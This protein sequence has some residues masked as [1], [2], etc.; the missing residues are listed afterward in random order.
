MFNFRFVLVC[1]GVELDVWF[2]FERHGHKVF[3]ATAALATL[4][5]LFKPKLFVLSMAKN[6]SQ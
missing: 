1:L 2:Y 4:Y 3:V 5:L 6:I